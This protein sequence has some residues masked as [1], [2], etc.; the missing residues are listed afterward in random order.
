MIFFA[1]IASMLAKLDLASETRPVDSATHYLRCFCGKIN[2]GRLCVS[3]DV[4]F[5]R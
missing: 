2:D 4:L 3:P 5:G 1:V